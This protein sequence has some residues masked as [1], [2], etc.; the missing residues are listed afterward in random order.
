M[1]KC[2]I[3]KGILTW[4]GLIKPNVQAVCSVCR[5]QPVFKFTIQNALLKHEKIDMAL[6]AKM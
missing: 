6:L 1:I 2:P 3:F 5:E 4:H